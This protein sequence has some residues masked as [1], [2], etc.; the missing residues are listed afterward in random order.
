MGC[1]PTPPNLARRPRP[2]EVLLGG[3]GLWGPPNF[4][5]NSLGKVTRR[6]DPV[7][8]ATI[9]NYFPN[10]IDLQEVRQVNGQST[11]LLEMY[12]YNAQHLPLTI[13]DAAGQTT[14]YTYNTAGQLLTVVTPPRGG[15]TLAQRTTT[16]SYDTNG[17]LQSV[18]GP[19]AGM[20]AS[21]TYDG[22]GRVRTKT[23][24]DGYVLTYDYDAL[25]R[26]TR[27]TYPDGTYDETAY[28]RLDPEKR[29]DRLGRWTH[30]FHDALRRVVSVRDPAGRTTT[31][32][33]C[34]CGSLD[35]LI[36]GNNNAT[37]WERDLQG[38]VTREVRAD[39]SATTFVYENTTSR[40][41]QRTDAKNQTITYQYAL[42]DNTNQVTYTNAQN[43]TP[44]LT[45]TF[46]PVYDRLTTIVDGT[47]TTTYAYHPVGVLGAGEVSSIDGPLANDTITYSYDELGRVTTRQVNGAAS[48]LSTAY[49]ARGR[50]TSETNALGA[51]TYIYDGVTER[52]S[53]LTYPNG[54][55]T[56]YAYFDNLGDHRLQQIHNR[57]SGGAT[58]SKFDYTNDV[59]GN[60]KTWSQQVGTNPAK[61]LTFGYDAADQLMTASTSPT[62]TAPNRFAYAYDGAGNRTAEQVDD[63]VTGATYNNLNQLVSQQPGGALLFRG[64][65]NEP[66]TVTVGGKP[67][68]VGT[69]NTFVQ[70]APVGSGTSTVAVVA[71]DPS[72]NVR[73]NTYQVSQT[74]ASKSFTYDL[75]GNLTSD[76]ARTFEWDAE[77]RLVAV[78]Q[79]STTLASFTYDSDGR[80]AQQVAGGLTRTYVYE[81]DDIV[82]ERL[83]S[84]STTQNFHAARL[85][86]HLGTK[87]TS[88]A[89]AYFAKDHLGSVRDVVNGSGAVTLR[90]DYDPFGNLLSGGSQSGYGYTGREWDAA[91]GL[92]YFRARYYAPTMGTF[93]SEDPAAY[94]DGLSLYAY[95]SANPVKLADPTG[96]QW[97]P[98]TPSQPPGCGSGCPPQVPQAAQNLCQNNSQA[99]VWDWATRRCIRQRCR[100]GLTIS[101]THGSCT[102]PGNMGRA[103]GPNA[104]AVCP[105]QVPPGGPCLE[106]IIAHEMMHL[107]G[108]PSTWRGK[109]HNVMTARVK[110]TVPCPF[111]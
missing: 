109:G 52:V 32:Q 56:S 31:Q 5:K 17:Y 12:T 51:F 92:N 22:Y 49:D 46:D 34:T 20:T 2:R 101:C 95:V 80:R 67:A 94:T 79:N 3:V 82:E 106:R 97:S 91:L 69:D 11:D 98:P 89:V 74:G 25:D 8:R 62:G 9:F 73:T 90:R 57:L 60:V 35:K 76:G 21:Y 18:A 44:N 111:P 77:N 99:T 68:Q 6:T 75:N 87:D 65:V 104:I 70:S 53:T 100:S 39:S 26:L 78:K 103:I 24:P 47:G 10:G 108:G 81:G 40:L 23:D 55:T 63:V 13:T 105:G 16:Y 110:M 19:L 29:R 59:V 27:T 83:S 43:P 7:G 1:G 64:S 30:I 58:L 41:K 84:G 14:T 48:T 86:D 33:W 15:L 72:G 88:G 45:L 4:P 54:Q 38:R 71:T 93:I 96:M 107:C 36:D 61:V 66:A 28:N 42:D 85:D 102:V 50:I 37:T